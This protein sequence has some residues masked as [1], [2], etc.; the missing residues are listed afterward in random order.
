MARP[1][2]ETY[3]RPGTSSGHGFDPIPNILLNV[4]PL[5]NRQPIIFHDQSI[6]D[7]IVDPEP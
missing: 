6:L 2:Q 3:I 1:V 5:Q 7:I 4:H